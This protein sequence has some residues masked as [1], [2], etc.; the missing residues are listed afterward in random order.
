M[1]LTQET[2]ARIESIL[3]SHEVVL[4]MKGSPQRPQCGFS[5]KASAIVGGLVADYAHIDVLQDPE[6]REGIKV[7]GQWPTVPQLYVKGE[8]VGGSDIIEQMMNTGELHALLGGAA[9]DRTPP[10]ITISDEAAA[11]IR[12]SMA[13]QGEGLSL[14]MAVDAKFAS[15][16]EL[17]QATGQEITAESNGITVH[18]D[19][20][21]APRASGISIDWIDRGVQGAGL[22]ISNPNAPAQVQPLEVADL[23]ARLAEFTVVDIRPPQA[24][25]TAPFPKPHQV[26]DEDSHERLAALPTDTRLAFLCHHGN[27]SRQAAE[28]FRSLGFTRVFNVEGGIDAWSVQI[29]SSVPRY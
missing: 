24:R 16:F 10:A 13:D 26:L 4:F 7:Y 5:M 22:S 29:D 9:P 14:H 19:L 8:L 18:F 6:V 11:Q 28:H 27:S 1:S 17:K 12:K 15:R 25:A 23:A 21:S 3:S 2:R 20:A